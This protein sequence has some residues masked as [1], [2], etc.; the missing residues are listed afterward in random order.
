MIN[1]ASII[2]LNFLKM[3]EGLDQLVAGGTQ[4]FHIDLMDGHYVPN[5][6]MPIKFISELKKAYPEI[7]MDV[8]IMV[9]NPS[10]YVARLAEAG[11]DY[12][13]FHTD[14]TP[15]VRRLINEIR[16][17]GMK[18]GIIINPSQRVDHIVPF[19]EYVDMVMLM[20][21]EPGF[22]GQPFLEGGL[23]R[24][25]AIADLRK[26]YGCSFLINVDGGIDY[27]KGKRCKEI[28]VDVIVGTLHNIFGQP[29][30]ITE[31]CKRFCRELG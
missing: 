18:P 3:K 29:E 30:G 4:M 27:A 10:D 15:F 11:A 7:I 21:V 19:I 14:S 9:T 1:S 31:A 17:A 16:K 26:Q 2:N 22:A 6:C 23:E 20:T 5:L 24:L 12:V 28:G 8:H 25:Q 13:T